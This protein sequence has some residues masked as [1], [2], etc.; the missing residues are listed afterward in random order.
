[1]HLAALQRRAGDIAGAD[2][3]VK[4]AGI[5]NAQCMLFDVRPVVTDNSQYYGD[6]PDDALR[7]GFDGYVRETFDIDADGHVKNA[8]TVLAYPP[9]VFR[10]GAEDAISHRRYLAPVIDGASVGCDGHTT[11]I[12]YTANH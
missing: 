7:W 8:R 6:F 2:T 11:S 12:R 3:K 10:S 1:L 4:A 9:F 5:T